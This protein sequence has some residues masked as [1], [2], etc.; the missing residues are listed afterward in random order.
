MAS[1][2]GDPMWFWDEWQ[3]AADRHNLQQKGWAA[4][5]ST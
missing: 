2:G 5:Q 3:A 1:E 4:K